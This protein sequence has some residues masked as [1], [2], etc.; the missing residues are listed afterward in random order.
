MNSINLNPLEYS[1]SAD[2]ILKGGQ[3]ILIW[4]TCWPSIRH[5]VAD[6]VAVSSDYPKQNINKSFIC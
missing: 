6:V 3:Q 4:Y 1:W 5:I 2:V